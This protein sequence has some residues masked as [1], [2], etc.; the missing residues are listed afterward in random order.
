MR[1]AALAGQ[2]PEQDGR[3]VLDVRALRGGHTVGNPEEAKQAHDVVE[4]HPRGVA[5]GAADGVD[6]WRPVGL[7]EPP[8]VQRRD[9]PV[10]AVSE[11]LVR[12][13]AHAH[14][15]REVVAPPPRVESVRGEAD[16]HVG[17]EP[18]LARGPRH[19]PVDM[20]LL[21][22]VKRDS[23]G[24]GLFRGIGPIAPGRA[25]VLAP[26]IER[27]ELMKRGALPLDERRE[28]VGCRRC[29]KDLLQRLRLEA[30]HLAVVN[31]ALRVQR[32]GSCALAREVDPFRSLDVLRTQVHD[33]AKAPCRRVVRRGLVWQCGRL[34]AERVEQ[35]GRR[36]HAAREASETAQVGE[37]AD[38]PAVLRA[39][40]VQLDR[41]AP[42]ALRR[43]PAGLVRQV[44]ALLWRGHI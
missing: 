6:E 8:R 30:E 15:R 11:E 16:R 24:I 44:G 29:A 31:E 35:D 19:L 2:E 34:R 37:V 10:L 3:R 18:D 36:A 28:A 41:P 1:A 17:D 4:T 5:G 25:V 23:F 22:F 27:R 38:A 20:E 26:H 40:R 21:P 12:R 32:A 14:V 42:R 33:V 13:R 43:V 39:Q 9:A 7:P